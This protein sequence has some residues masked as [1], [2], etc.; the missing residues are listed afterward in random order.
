MKKMVLLCAA[1]LACG[2]LAG[3]G[4]HKDNSSAK[5][6]SLKAENSSLKAKKS[7]SHKTK[8]HRQ[9]SSSSQNKNDNT[10]SVAQ[11][12]KVN[13][14]NSTQTAKS[15]NN[16]QTGKNIQQANQSNGDPRSGDWHNDP[17]LWADVQNNDHWQGSMYQ[18]ATPQE[19]YNYLEDNHDYWAARDP[20]YNDPGYYLNH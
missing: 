11:T 10:G 3:C 8:H 20:H 6:S 17:E 2:G 9:S 16:G 5:I 19:R 13:G 7:S 14:S 1:V 18:N 4:Q 15:S 12:A